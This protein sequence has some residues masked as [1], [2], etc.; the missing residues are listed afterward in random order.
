MC[1][2]DERIVAESEVAAPAERVWAQIS[3][4][5]AIRM[6]HPFV[7]ENIAESWNGIGSKDKVTY[8]N[9]MKFDR[10]VVNW[11]EGI[12]YDLKVTEN[13]KNELLTVWRVTP[14]SDKNCTFKVT[15]HVKFIEKFPFPIRWAL[16]TWKIKP[17]FSQ[18]F[19]LSMPGFV[20]YAET[21]EP[22]TRNQFGSH[23]MFS[24]QQ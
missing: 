6:W 20:H 16:L 18:Y 23:P 15:T 8:C 22:V 7:Q 11:L 9:D 14:I 17:M 5:A 21:R 4:P 3:A 24:P 12:G 2:F 1:K 10:E 13:G 19:G